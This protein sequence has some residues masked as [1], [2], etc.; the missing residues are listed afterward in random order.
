MGTQL[1]SSR[2]LGENGKILTTLWWT[3]LTTPSGRT[4]TVDQVPAHPRRGHRD[5]ERAARNPPSALKLCEPGGHSDAEYSKGPTWVERGICRLPQPTSKL[6]G[7]ATEATMKYAKD[8][9][10]HPDLEMDVP[11]PS[12]V[13]QPRS[14]RSNVGVIVTHRPPTWR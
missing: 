6:S 9:V 11:V 14:P 12:E 4:Q 10:R 13:T 5:V 7:K 8:T 3:C 2:G 1:W